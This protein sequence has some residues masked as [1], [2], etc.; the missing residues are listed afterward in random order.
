MSISSKSYCCRLL[1]VAL[2]IY[3][4][5]YIGSAHAHGNDAMSHAE[6]RIVRG[7]AR[8]SNS[9]SQRFSSKS[10][11][12]VSSSLVV[13]VP[14]V[15]AGPYPEQISDY[16]STTNLINDARAGSPGVTTDRLTIVDG[17]P[18]NLTVNI[19]NVTGSVASPLVGA[20]LFIWHCDAIGV[21]SS[22]DLATASSNKED[23]QGQYWAR[24]HYPT[25]SSGSVTYQT[26][27]PGWYNP[28]A[29]HIHLRVRLSN[30]ITNTT[31]IVTTQLFIPQNLTYIVNQ[32][33]PYSN[34]TTPGVTL[35]N[36][37]IYNGITN[38]TLASLLILSPIGS[39]TAGYTASFNMGIA[40][41][42]VESGEPDAADY[43]AVVDGGSST[44]GSTT[45]SGGPPGGSTGGAPPGGISSSS[46]SSSSSSTGA[47]GL[48]SSSST[49]VATSS[50]STA[51]TTS[52][53][54]AIG[55]SAI[56]LFLTVLIS[57]AALLMRIE[58]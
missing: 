29:V 53:A 23:T 6:V 41:T 24:A 38:T 57:V 35:S 1:V 56:N 5:L 19:Y 52:S 10:T 45:G 58:H 31:F 4:V 32:L 20:D 3:T 34:N 36:D 37:G 30:P 12:S 17:I 21:Y 39:V 47:A 25:D 8:S 40:S 55:F 50:N 13:M 51:T 26:I 54:N 15:T 44:T 46:S 28:R 33:Q 16:P 2:C 18:L 49:G 14:D 43:Y 42:V 9:H 11:G 22:V 48:S 7:V 27:I